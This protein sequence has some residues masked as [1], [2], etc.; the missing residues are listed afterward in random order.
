M[1]RAEAVAKS[2]DRDRA[3]QLLEMVAFKGRGTA[4]AT[5]AEIQLLTARKER[6]L[7]SAKLDD[8]E[9]ARRTAD[10]RILADRTVARA[11]LRLDRARRLLDRV[12][13][14]AG[15][16]AT[17]DRTCARAEWAAA[18]ARRLIQVAAFRDPPA[19][20]HWT[21][22]PEVVVT[23][24]RLVSVSVLEAWALRAVAGGRF[25]FAVRTARRGAA[26]DPASDS[27]KRL[28]TEAEAGLART[29]VLLGSPPPG[30]R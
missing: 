21:T 5:R 9:R 18:S 26:L 14:A 23:E 19:T 7:E 16:D 12:A 28:V 30:K 4:A 3:V 8:A 10:A 6:E 2:G 20:V 17:A 13:R 15:G 22:A 1:K 27:L 25:D 24:S 11:R 29:G